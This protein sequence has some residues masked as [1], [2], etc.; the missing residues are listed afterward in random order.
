MSVIVPLALTAAS[1]IYDQL[2]KPDYSAVDPSKISGLNYTDADMNR[3]MRLY[4]GE[5]D[6]SAAVQS[7][8]IKGY[9]AANRLPQGAVLDA[10]GGVQ[11]RTAQGMERIVPAL[12]DK[13]RGILGNYYNLLNQYGL[14]KMEYQNDWL[15]RVQ[16]GFGTLG[17]IATL[18]AEGKLDGGK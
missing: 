7:Q 1:M 8:R 17:N 15:N 9:G 16:G 5:L 10:L 6:K 11:E 3:D 2:N 14:G 13:Q 18:W 4:R 12:R